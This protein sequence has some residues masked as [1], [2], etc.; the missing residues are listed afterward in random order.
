MSPEEGQSGFGEYAALLRRRRAWLLTII[1]A[2]ILLSLFFAY[3]LPALYRS[4]A[5]I[6]LEKASVSQDL[7]RATVANY[8]EDEADQQIEVISRRVLS[9]ETLSELVRNYDPYPDQP[10]LSTAE[11][12]QQILEHTEMERI[13][14]VT[15]VRVEKSSAFNLYYEN[16]NPQRAAAVTAKLADLFL[17]YHQRIRAES[18]AT[19]TKLLAG[20]ANSLT[21]ELR[22]LDDEYAQLKSR[23]GGALPDSRDRNEEGRDRAQRNLES[24][25]RD[26]RA[27]QDRVA[28][29]GIQLSGISP[30]L[31]TN[32]GDLTD[33]NTV[34]A[35]L[36][37]AEQRYTPDHPDVKRLRRALQT[38]MAQGANSSTTLAQNAD[39]PEYR[40]VASQLESARRDTL[41]AQA[42]VARAR[43]QIDQYTGYLAS[44]PGAERDFADLQRRRESLQSQFQQIQDKLKSAQFGEV[45]ES[46]QDSGSL[47]EHFSMLRTPYATRTPYSPNR[48]G[49]I[50]LGTV[51]GC[52]IAAIAVSIAESGDATVRGTKDVGGYRGLTVL[53][54]IPEIMRPGDRRRKRLV[55]GSVT[56]IYVLLGILVTV[57]IIRAELRDHRVQSA[58]L[59]D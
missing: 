52:A 39:N 2:S 19:T 32:K 31:M 4:S 27:A 28:L 23:Y 51:L 54:G 15:M 56:A 25:E 7:I 49:L 41:A 40:T 59:P 46:D 1:P 30:N 14:P 38:L 53:G 21:K 36:A 42:I 44:S 11:K 43:Q 10:N 34:K 37:D 24:A 57:T 17:T 50:L 48:I 55:L 12:A 26:L 47:S 58:S 13:D 16:P 5:T 45:V 9:T 6:I 20:R 3:A 18:A 22:K 35:Q 29:L 33:L 8:K